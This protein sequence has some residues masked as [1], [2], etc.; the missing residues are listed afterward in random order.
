MA[1]LVE[2]G[3]I[4]SNCQALLRKPA[5][6]KKLITSNGFMQWLSSV[7]ENH[8]DTLDETSSV[9]IRLCL[10]KV[11]FRH[12]LL[13]KLLLHMPSLNSASSGTLE[14]LTTHEP[15]DS[16]RIHLCGPGEF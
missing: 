4:I 9:L 11:N 3:D 1:V 16:V 15:L 6:L 2:K 7:C 12:T 14:L 10:T 13:D 5:L 8:L